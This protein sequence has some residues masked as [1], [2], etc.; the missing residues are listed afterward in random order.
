MLTFDP[1]QMVKL[2]VMENVLPII[3]AAK[4]LFEKEHDPLLKDLMIYLKELMQVRRK[5]VLLISLHFERP[6]PRNWEIYA[7][8]TP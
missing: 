6:D 7:L 5:G 3:I 8:S 4:H 1:T 2:N